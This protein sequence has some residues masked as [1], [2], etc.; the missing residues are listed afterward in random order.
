MSKKKFDTDAAIE[1]LSLE[2]AQQKDEH[3][4]AL[5]QLGASF[6][7]QLHDMSKHYADEARRVATTHDKTLRDI[8]TQLKDL[9]GVHHQD[10]IRTHALYAAVQSTTGNSFSLIMDRAKLFEEYIQGQME[11]ATTAD[12]NDTAVNARS[13]I[14]NNGECLETA[15]DGNKCKL[16]YGHG[17]NHYSRLATPENVAK[18]RDKAHTQTSEER[19]LAEAL[20]DTTPVTVV[21]AADTPNAVAT[22]MTRGDLEAARAVPVPSSFVQLDPEDD[23]RC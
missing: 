13:L 9:L 5:Q 10:D 14:D 23:A 15:P 7:D 20:Q 2:L 12:S 11:P 8:R 16:P 3:D 4:R 19:N 18:S 21:L 1:K 17:G 22:Q 6:A